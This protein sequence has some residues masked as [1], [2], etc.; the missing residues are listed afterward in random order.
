MHR[1]IVCARSE[2]FSKAC[3]DSFK[4]SWSFYTIEYT[5]TPRKE[6]ASGEITLQEDDPDMVDRMLH[7]FYTS[8]YQDDLEGARPLLVNAHMYAIGDKYRIEALKGLAEEKF[9]QALDAGWDIVSFPE[10]IVT[11]Y[12]TTLPSDRGLRDCLMPVLVKHKRELHGHEG[13]NSL[14]KDKLSDGEFA[15]DVIHAWANLGSSK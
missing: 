2:Y 6:G 9:L 7:F 11:V 13:F 15:L 14:I 10:V 4:V 3:E 12:T 5:L 1:V 8:G